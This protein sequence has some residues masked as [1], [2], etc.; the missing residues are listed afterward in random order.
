MSSVEVIS[1]NH[2]LLNSR[3]KTYIAS[4]TC[5]S[6]E[7]LKDKT[8]FEV[9]SLIRD[10]AVPLKQ[11]DNIRSR[12]SDSGKS[13]SCSPMPLDCIEDSVRTA[14]V[15]HNDNATVLRKR[16]QERAF[17]LLSLERNREKFRT[18]RNR[19]R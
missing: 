12:S 8:V 19:L 3:S 2:N 17:I 13:S 16:I 4:Q 5:H 7:V 1:H 18:I 15:K 10:M 9:V 6:S 14:D 11:F